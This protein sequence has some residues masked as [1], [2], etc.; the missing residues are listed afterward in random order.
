M[1][2]WVLEKSEQETG[3]SRDAAVQ[4]GL[5]SDATE[6]WCVRQAASDTTARPVETLST[7]P[8]RLGSD[9]HD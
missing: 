6:G 5:D 3:W 1:M 9:S 4:P 7:E 2:S 8:W